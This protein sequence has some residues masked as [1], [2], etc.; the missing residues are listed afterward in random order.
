MTN[1]TTGATSVIKM[2]DNTASMA[3]EY[4]AADDVCEAGSTG[5]NSTASHTPG[6]CFYPAEWGSATTD[7]DFTVRVAS[8]A[9]ANFLLNV[10]NDETAAYR[11]VMVYKAESDGTVMQYMPSPDSYKNVAEIK[12]DGEFNTVFFYARPTYRDY[13][14]IQA[15]MC[16]SISACP[17]PWRPS[18]RRSAKR[19]MSATSGP[20]MTTV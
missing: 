20:Q 17:L 8:T 14:E 10:A 15:Q 19:R 12:G 16:C 4:L 6:I 9:D 5:D 13:L 3:T 2:V 11:I 18:T 7:G 1:T